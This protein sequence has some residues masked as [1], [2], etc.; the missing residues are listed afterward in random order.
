[1]DV[2]LSRNVPELVL[3]QP[4]SAEAFSPEPGLT[5]RILANNANLMLV[6]HRMADGWAGTRHSHPHDQ[7]VYIISGRLKVCVGSETF[8]AGPGVSFIVKGD[9]EHQAWALEPA[10]VLDTFTP[11]RHDYLPPAT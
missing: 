7:L 6:E 2:T 3:A 1:M 4:N 9:V 11:T 5:R 10:H 8:E